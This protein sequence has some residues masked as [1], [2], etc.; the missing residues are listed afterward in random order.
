MRAHEGLVRREERHNGLYRTRFLG[1]TFALRGL[2]QIKLLTRFAW[3]AIR[4]L[5]EAPALVVAF[6]ELGDGRAHVGEISKD[7]AVD[8]LLLER[9][10]PALDD[11]VMLSV[12]ARTNRTLRLTRLRQLGTKKPVTH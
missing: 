1:H 5:L 10:I 11:P 3:R 6:D 12:T 9:A 8:G 7:P 2:A 4:Q